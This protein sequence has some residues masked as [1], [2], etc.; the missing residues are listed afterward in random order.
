[1][2]GL[3]FNDGKLPADWEN[4]RDL[5][6]DLYAVQY[7]PSGY[8]NAVTMNLLTT[9]TDISEECVITVQSKG[10]NTEIDKISASVKIPA[11]K[12]VMTLPSSSG[13]NSATFASGGT[14]TM[15]T[16]NGTQIATYSYNRSNSNRTATNNAAIE[17]TGVTGSTSVYVTYSVS[18]MWGG[19]T[20]YKSPSFTINDATDIDGVTLNM[21]AN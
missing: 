17:L 9:I 16:S 20:T 8:L 6:N 14:I 2:K 3:A 12:L 15:Y 7:K 18:S 5:G 11:G 1:M 10:Y 4:W 21:S 19:S 13:W